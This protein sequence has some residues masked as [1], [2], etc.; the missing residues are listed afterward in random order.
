MDNVI[1][2]Y[3]E[4]G[5]KSG[6][7][8]AKM[9]QALRQR[10]NNRLEHE[11]VEFD[12]VSESQGR[13]IIRDTVREAAEVAADTPGVASASPCLKTTPEISE[14]KDA[15][16]QLEIGSSFGV[17]A[18]R[19]GEHDF[20]SMDVEREIGSFVEHQTGAEVDLDDPDTWIGVDVREDE[21]YLFNE[22]VEGVGGL[23]VGVESSMA[24]LVSGG[25]DSPVAAFEVMRRGSNVIPVYFYNRPLAAGDHVLRFEESVKELKKYYPS[26]NWYYYK[27]DLKEVNQKLMESV[28]RG[29]MVLHRAL[30]FRVAEEL[31]E[32]ECLK[33]LVSGEA[34]GQKSSQTPQ[35][36]YLASSEVDMPVHR[37]LLSRDK[38]DIVEEAKWIGTFDISTVDSA[39]RSISPD[40]P[41]TSLD[42]SSFKRLKNDVGFENLVEK[43]VSNAEKVRI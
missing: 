6:G 35:N 30:L 10:V 2:R 32:D 36:L 11:D 12:K 14:L 21:A 7:V 33:G 28:D 25:I 42:E 15:V 37:P 5:R 29:R 9:R 41:A 26:R 3:S 22:R 17:K 20:D 1:V 31:A 39:C 19:A 27:V 8:R 24:A 43:A 16:K 13:L 18:N 40:N 4:I 23:P 34:I 38:N